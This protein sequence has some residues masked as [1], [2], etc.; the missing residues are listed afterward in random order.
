MIDIPVKIYE[1]GNGCQVEYRGKNLYSDNPLSGVSRRLNTGVLSD[2]TCYLLPSPILGYGIKELKEQIGKHSEV[3]WLEREFHLARLFNKQDPSITCNIEGGYL[4]DDASVDSFISSLPLHKFRKVRLIVLSGGYRLHPSFYKKAEQAV[5]EELRRYW[6]NR[7]TIIHLFRLWIK[8]T[9]QNLPRLSEKKNIRFSLNKPTVILGAGE[10]LEHIISWIEKVRKQIIV[11]SVD[12]ALPA[13]LAWGITPDYIFVLESQITNLQDFIGMGRINSILLGDISSYPNLYRYFSHMPAVFFSTKFVGNQLLHR[14]KKK[15]FI[16]KTIPPLGSVGVAALEITVRNRR[17]IPIFI[18]G[19][20][21]SYSQG[22]PHAKGTYSHLLR[23]VNSDRLNPMEWLPAR[24]GA[25]NTKGKRGECL[26]TD[27]VL[28][29][30]KELLISRTENAENI[31]DIGK[32]GL[33]LDLPQINDFPVFREIVQSHTCDGKPGTTFNA[34]TPSQKNILAFF[35]DELSRLEEIM[36]GVTD[37]LNDSGKKFPDELKSRII[38]CDYIFLDF[39]DYQPDIIE[40]PDRSF[41]KRILYSIA[42]YIAYI[43]LEI[44]TLISIGL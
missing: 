7:I 41:L 1:T 22:K 2:Y 34:K 29:S 15:G 23:M 40:N 24:K 36:D 27:K 38:A 25:Y 10:S 8:N 39:P 16:N 35:R 26:Q 28:A 42:F 32:S 18:G 44:E 13:L 14:L 4:E 9:I 30:Y 12:T 3:Y 33:P 19:F 37:Y 5:Q 11:I 20:D 6:R 43:K 21:F 31:F 17:N